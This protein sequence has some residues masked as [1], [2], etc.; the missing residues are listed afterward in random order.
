MSACFLW[1][2][3]TRKV[4]ASVLHSPPPPFLRVLLHTYSSCVKHPS[5][6]CLCFL[7]AMIWNDR[8]SLFLLHFHSTI[9]ARLSESWVFFSFFLIELHLT[10]LGSVCILCVSMSDYILASLFLWVCFLLFSWVHKSRWS[11]LQNN[12]PPEFASPLSP[13]HTCS[14][15]SNT[16]ARKIQSWYHLKAITDITVNFS[17]LCSCCPS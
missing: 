3:Q 17:V 6:S 10:A 4:S 9:P 5:G 7:T 13:S 2:Q 16:N 14:F 15:T 11:S 8:S 1:M 12:P